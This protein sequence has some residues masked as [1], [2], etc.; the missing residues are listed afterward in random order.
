VKKIA[1]VVVLGVLLVVCGCAALPPLLAAKGEDVLTAHFLDIPVPAEFKYLK[2]KSY[3][4]EY[5]WKKVRHGRLLYRGRIPPSEIRDFY[6]EKM[7]TA[8]WEEIGCAGGEKIALTFVKGSGDSK[9]RCQ[10]TIFSVQDKTL[11][12]IHLDPMKK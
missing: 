6:R 3:Y 10:V 1:I 12:E 8:N 9:E 7:L 11:V 2:E 4:F 5:D